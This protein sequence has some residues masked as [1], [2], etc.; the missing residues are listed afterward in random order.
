MTALEP[1][2]GWQ[3]VLEG[4][5]QRA[6][7][8]EVGAGLRS[9]RIGEHELLDSFGVGSAGED[10]RGKV[11]MPWPNRIRD[12]RYAFGGGEHRTPLTEPERG[13]ALHGL[14]LWVNWRPIRRTPDRVALAYL[15][16]PQPGYPFTLSLEVEYALAAGGLAITLRAVNRGAEPAPFGT[17]VHPYV[18]FGG[19]VDDAQLEL[20]AAARVPVDEQ[21]LLPAG[22]PVPVADT[23]YDF[24]AARTLGPQALDDCFTDLARGSDGLARARFAESGGQREFEIWMDGSFGHLQVFTA[25]ATADPARHRRSVTIEP[26]TCAPD[27]FN[28]G[29][30]LVV[31]APGEAFEGRCGLVARG[32]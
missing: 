12:G 24:R 10:Y 6:V 25:D 16:H 9:W 23:E 3:F 2:T 11:L 26:M 21:R 15:L 20:P 14:A 4:D 31:L 17:G 30:G 27:A 29:D 5:G 28:S 7:V 32:F 1:P 8:T 22:P 19:P 18:T 13:A